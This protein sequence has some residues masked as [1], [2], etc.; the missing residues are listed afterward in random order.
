MKRL[1]KVKAEK[2]GVTIV[3]APVKK[4]GRGE[5]LLKIKAAA[6]CG[7][8]MH[9]YDWN[10]WAAG[11]YGGCLPLPLGHEF[12]AEV[13]ETGPNVAGFAV[14]ERVAG[15]THLGCGTCSQCMQGRYHTCENL[16]IFSQ[17]RAGCFAEYATVPAGFLMKVP[18]GISDEEAAILEPFGIALRTVWESEV[19]GRNVLV[20]G[21]GPVG[22][23][24]I[25]AVKALGA[26][27][28][29]AA[30]TEDYRTDFAGRLGADYIINPARESMA[31]RVKELTGGDGV[32]AILEFTGSPQ[33]IKSGLDCLTSGGRM[34]C[35][36]LPS[37]PVE[38][39]IAKYVVT[40]E[41]TLRGLYGRQIPNT[42]HQAYEL[43]KSGRVDIRPVITHRFPLDRYE[44]AFRLAE[45]K[46]CGKILFEQ[47]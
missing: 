23:L 32:D 30:D 7:T 46:R 36:G 31:D 24:A 1:V 33:A 41:I 17:S 13:V 38:I 42:W 14:G 40:K 37:R 12:C 25:P 16:R 43:I 44:E 8:D 34:V 27:R 39:D 21:C 10:A 26:L 19:S 3:D 6:I 47:E 22:L 9:I 28:V 18:D 15:E 29:I 45:S 20:L 11:K 2:D 35:A 4:P 5:V